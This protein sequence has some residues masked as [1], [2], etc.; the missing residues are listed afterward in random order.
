MAMT[1]NSA[2]ILHHSKIVTPDEQGR[3]KV[4]LE[5]IIYRKQLWGLRIHGVGISYKKNTYAFGIKLSCNQ[6]V[7]LFNIMSPVSQINDDPYEQ[8]LCVFDIAAQKSSKKLV[9]FHPPGNDVFV[10]NNPTNFL[11]FNITIVHE[12]EGKDDIDDYI[13][14]DKC[15]IHFSYIRLS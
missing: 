3:L 10:I 8:P 2:S 1:M 13:Y 11:E 4:H 12:T 15:F 5:E 14:A 7:K 6:I 9:V